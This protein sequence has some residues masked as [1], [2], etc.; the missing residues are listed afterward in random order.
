M[1][2]KRLLQ[3]DEKK[4]TAI[5]IAEDG[6]VSKGYKYPKSK[7]M[8]F[9]HTI[10]LIA[11]GKVNFWHYHNKMRGRGRH[12]VIF[13]SIFLVDF[14][15]KRWRKKGRIGIVFE[16]ENRVFFSP[17]LDEKSGV[18]CTDFGAKTGCFFTRFSGW[19]EAGCV[20]FSVRKIGAFSRLFRGEGTL[21][22]F[23]FEFCEKTGKKSTIF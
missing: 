16:D 22:F 9:Y 7:Y 2:V 11:S 14:T 13:V 19:K 4:K 20:P 10:M 1:G 8:V 17:F 3:S 21:F 18:F 15:I 6:R 5:P 12:F 23:F